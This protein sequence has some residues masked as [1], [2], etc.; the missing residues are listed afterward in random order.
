[1]RRSD[2]DNL[3]GSVT[4]EAAR[5]FK[6]ARVV[7]AIGL[8]GSARVLEL[9]PGPSFYRVSASTTSDTTLNTCGHL[10]R[11]AELDALVSGS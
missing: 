11:D 7:E 4:A 6:P 5:N 2:D 3:G 1:M 8:T 9:R 10:W